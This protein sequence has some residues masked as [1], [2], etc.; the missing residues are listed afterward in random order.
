M[1]PETWTLQKIN[2]KFL[3]SSDTWCWRR[4]EKISVSDRVRNEELLLGGNVVRN[5]ILK[6]IKKAIWIVT[7]C[8]GN[9]F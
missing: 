9:V 5:V 4:V 7:S 8:V 2:H 1:V 3:A 6:T